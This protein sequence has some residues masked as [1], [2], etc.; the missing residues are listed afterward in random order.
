M[1]VVEISAVLKVSSPGSDK[2]DELLVHVV[3]D[4]KSHRK[5]VEFGLVAVSLDKFRI[6]DEAE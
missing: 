4:F 6:R 1:S 5:K 3:V 2:F